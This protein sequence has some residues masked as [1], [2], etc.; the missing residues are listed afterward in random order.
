MVTA[1]SSEAP[2][3]L[4]TAVAT[5]DYSVCLYTY[6]S[7]GWQYINTSS[8]TDQVLG[9]ALSYIYNES[10]DAYIVAN[11]NKLKITTLVGE[12]KIYRFYSMLKLDRIDVFISDLYVADWNA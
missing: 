7:S 1:V 10:I 12:N 11:K 6:R 9:V 8:F 2:N 5:I 3:L 4:F